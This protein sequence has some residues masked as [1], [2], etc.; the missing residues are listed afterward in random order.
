[1]TDFES[2]KH[3]TEDGLKVINLKHKK[4]LVTILLSRKGY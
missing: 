3:V 4:P 2:Y 1:M